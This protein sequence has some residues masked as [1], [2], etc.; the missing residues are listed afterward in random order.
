MAIETVLVAVG[1]QDSDRID[2]LTSTAV[3]IADPLEAT[4]IVAHVF[5]DEPASLP[6]GVLPIAGQH[7][8]Y[9]LSDAEY[10]EAVNPSAADDDSVAD[11]TIRH[12][13][14]HEIVDRLE[15]TGVDYE[16]RGA[17][18]E[19]GD[20]LVTLADEVDAD[21]VVVGGRQRSPTDKVVFGSV[22]QDVLLSSPCPVTFVRD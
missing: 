20:A 13:I 12:E 19:P 18:G 1:D 22:A 16:T 14:V 17:V 15:E 5:P 10:D 11:A 9:V 7:R 8:P 3:E 6:E 4:V 21:R 2:R